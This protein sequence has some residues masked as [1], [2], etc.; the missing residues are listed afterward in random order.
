MPESDSDNRRIEQSTVHD[1]DVDKGML[2]GPGTLSRGTEQRIHGYIKA[3]DAA[4]TYVYAVIGLFFLL[5]ALVALGTTLWDFNIDVQQALS[6]AFEKQHASFART[7]INVVSSLLLVLIILE[8]LSTVIHYLKSHVVSLRPFLAIGIISAT[9]SILVVSARLS[10]ESSLADG[11][12]TMVGF[13]QSVIELSV[14][15]AVIVALGMTL[16]VLDSLRVE[17]IEP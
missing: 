8:I 15:A 5:G 4:N 6:L 7:I 11:H 12:V 17:S 1:V 2:P 10:I 3:L 13:L 14:S 16:K 9:R